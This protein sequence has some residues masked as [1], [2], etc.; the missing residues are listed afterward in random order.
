[1][2]EN[3]TRELFNVTV[4]TTPED[5]WA[6]DYRDRR[7]GQPEG[8][9]FR[10]THLFERQND[11]ESHTRCHGGGRASVA[12]PSGCDRLAW[13]KPKPASR[14][15]ILAPVTCGEDSSTWVITYCFS[16]SSS[17]AGS[18]VEQLA[19]DMGSQCWKWQVPVAVQCTPWATL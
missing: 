6:H 4:D 11:R 7:S 14:N 17:G 13:V 3:R 1:M 16:R 8:T 10:F 19:L 15:P 2:E 9:V 18:E 5:L 12:C